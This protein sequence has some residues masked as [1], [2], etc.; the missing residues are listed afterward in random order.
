MWSVAAFYCLGGRARSVA[1]SDRVL[2]GAFARY[3]HSLP[4][5]RGKMVR[6]YGRVAHAACK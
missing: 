2:A 5:L 4:A 6:Q 1:P 3:R